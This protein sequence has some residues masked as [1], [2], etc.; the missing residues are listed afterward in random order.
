[1]HGGDVGERCIFSVY[2]GMECRRAVGLFLPGIKK[3]DRNTHTHA[4]RESEIMY[5]RGE[6]RGIGEER[7]RS[8]CI[9]GNRKFLIRT[10]VKNGC[11]A[12]Q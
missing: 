9:I 5:G 6:G 10:R 7:D 11:L 12:P 2:L 3:K 4:R 1:M 8:R